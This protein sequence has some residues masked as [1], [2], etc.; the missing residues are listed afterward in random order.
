LQPA[1]RQ[2]L[3]SLSVFVQTAVI[4]PEPIWVGPF[5]GSEEEELTSA[6]WHGEVGFGF[7]LVLGKC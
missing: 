7:E 1:G 5:L 3:S 4:L 6:Q 2:I